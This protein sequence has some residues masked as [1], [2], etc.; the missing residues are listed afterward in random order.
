MAVLHVPAES[1]ESIRDWFHDAQIATSIHYPALSRHPLFDSE[2]CASA[3][4]AAAGVLTLPCYPD[5]SRADI[6]AVARTLR[7]AAEELR[8][9]SGT[10][11]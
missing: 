10:P 1:R 3:E 4:R 8:Q 11:S 2:R 7:T 6:E 9:K 5:M